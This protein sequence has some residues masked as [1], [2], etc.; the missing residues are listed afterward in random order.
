MVQLPLDWRHGSLRMTGGFGRGITPVTP[1]RREWTLSTLL[2][3]YLVVQLPNGPGFR[4]F[5]RVPNTFK[6][7]N[8]FRVIPR[9]EHIPSPEGLLAL[10]CVHHC[11]GVLPTLGLRV[12]ARPPWSLYM[13]VGWPVQVPG[14]VAFRL[15][16]TG[17]CGSSFKFC[18]VGRGWPTPIH[19]SGTAV[20]T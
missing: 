11:G 1:K 19:V 5:S 12:V 7:W 15:L 20:T 8:A 16:C 10:T 14:W 3:S 6:A 9:A 2:T 13:C 18:R 4:M 17:L